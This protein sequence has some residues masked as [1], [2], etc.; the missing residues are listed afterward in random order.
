MKKLL[1]LTLILLACAASVPAS[2]YLQPAVNAPVQ[3]FAPDGTLSQA[4]TINSVTLD[5]STSL[6]F[7]VY[8]PAD[9][10]ARVLP[11][12]AKSTYPSFTVPGGSW[13]IRVRNQATPF[14]NVSGCTSGHLQRQ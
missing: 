13:L 10:I 2:Q 8:C 3:G 12:S 7:G 6:A 14:L 9:A 4:L 5:L 11:T 1:A